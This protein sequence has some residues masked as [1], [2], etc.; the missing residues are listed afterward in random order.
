M[1]SLREYQDRDLSLI[2]S[3]LRNYISENEGS[4]PSSEEDLNNK[5]FIKKESLHVHSI[6]ISDSNNAGKRDWEEISNF[7]HF[8]IYYGI[9]INDVEAKDNKLYSNETKQQIFLINGRFG[10]SGEIFEKASYDL[11]K[12]MLKYKK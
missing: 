8:N 6:S 9:D 4:F 5:G 12:E 2:I 10:K 1:R 11:Y 3:C 7:E